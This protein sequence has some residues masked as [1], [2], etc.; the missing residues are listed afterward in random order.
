MNFPNVYSMLFKSEFTDAPNLIQNTNDFV[1]TLGL[2]FTMF[3][4]IIIAFMVLYKKVKFDNRAIIEFGIWSILIATFFL[5]HMH[6]RYM[7]MADVLGII[8]LL[9][10]KRKFYIPLIIEMISLYTYMYYLNGEN[11]GISIQVMSVLNFAMIIVFSFDMYKRYF[12]KGEKS[13]KMLDF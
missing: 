9:Y 7:F 2:Y 8:Y 4:F 10:N 6:D 11:A 13:A 12:A 1:G 5:P 3:V